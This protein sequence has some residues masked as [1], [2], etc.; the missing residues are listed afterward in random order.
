LNALIYATD[1]IIALVFL[2]NLIYFARLKK[3]QLQGLYDYQNGSKTSRYGSYSSMR[4][5][6]L[7]LK[8]KLVRLY[9]KL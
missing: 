3:L 6:G 1:W 5:V 9:R 8:H 2:V 7:T 4:G